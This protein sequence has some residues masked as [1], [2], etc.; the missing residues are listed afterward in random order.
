MLKLAMVSEHASPLAVLGGID[1]GGQNVYVAALAQELGR[2]GVRVTVYTRRD[3]ATVPKRVPLAPNVV[4][5]HV[6]AGPPNHIP[7]PIDNLLP[8]MDA[9]AEEL[10]T[11]WTHD[12]PHLVHSHFWMSGRA[13]IAAAEPLAIPVVHTFHALGVVKKRHQ[14]AKDTSPPSRIDE[15]RAILRGAR[16]IVPTCSDEIFELVRLGGDVSRMHVVPCGVNLRNFRPDGSAEP[17]TEPL[18]R[19]VSIGRLVERKGVDDVIR[20]LAELPN[21]ELVIAGGAP[22]NRLDADSDVQRLRTA[23]REAGVEER[24]VFRG[25]LERHEVPPLLRSADAVVC[26][27]WYEPFGIVAL[28]AMACGV[29]VV[30]SAVGGHIDTV[31]DRVTGLHVTARQPHAIAQAV[32]TL[33]QDDALRASL[34]RAGVRGVRERYTWERVA[35]AMLDVDGRVVPVEAAGE[36]RLHA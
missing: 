34:G 2:R 12:P 32:R 25:R 11:E 4:V 31:V 30:A 23:A 9:F 28:E 7:N 21:V 27:P 24:V 15:E 17:R 6:D 35:H 8:F 22:L 10:S 29:P 18:H 20:A 33:L 26:V 1:A 5:H 36:R 14:G 19:L 16:A 13:S 3:D